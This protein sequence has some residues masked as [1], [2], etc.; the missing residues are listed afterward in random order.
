M[1][2]RVLLATL[3]IASLAS[4][5]SAQTNTPDS[6]SNEIP[7]IDASSEEAAAAA[8]EAKPEPTAA[9]AVAADAPDPTDMVLDG[10]RKLIV[11]AFEHSELIAVYFAEFVNWV[12]RSFVRLIVGPEVDVGS[13]S[14][15]TARGHWGRFGSY[16]F[17]GRRRHA[18]REDDDDD[19]GNDRVRK[20]R[21]V[22][23]GSRIDRMD[24][25]VGPTFQDLYVVP[26]LGRRLDYEDM[27]GVERIILDTVDVVKTWKVIMEE[28][29]LRKERQDD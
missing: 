1:F 11:R 13:A 10:A 3:V 25:D 16:F 20:G 5:T 17:G 24:V 19:G 22:H 26:L 28:R 6:T 2:S 14:G 7:P 27:K 15:V 29:R 12:A 23:G 8:P 9:P 18:D 21:N 4:G